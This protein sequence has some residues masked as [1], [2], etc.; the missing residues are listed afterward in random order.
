[1]KLHSE[2]NIATV[3]TQLGKNITGVILSGG[4]SR[5]MGFNKSLLKISEK[6][7]I[8]IISDLMRSIFDKVV[9]ST[10]EPEKYDFLK[11]PMVKDIYTNYGPLSGIHSGLINSSTEKNFFLSC[12]LP[13][14]NEETI[15]YIVSYKTEKKITVPCFNGRTQHLCGVYSKS[16]IREIEELINNTGNQTGKNG[17]SII[18]V[19]NIIE[20]IGAELIMD[21][22]SNTF[23]EDVFFN[24][25]T[26]EDY[27]YVKRKYSQ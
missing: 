10:N 9:L 2:K 20:K 26:P 23:S 13:L 1:M 12:D 27:E 4:E 16:I 8:E 22:N 17:K 21:E 14:M 3:I 19:K 25:N 24:M 5:R 15:R 7:I 11:L 6:T 18:N